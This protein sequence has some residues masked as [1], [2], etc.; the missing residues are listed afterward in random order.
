MFVAS[1]IRS[2]YVYP[3][4]SPEGHHLVGDAWPYFLRH[5]PWRRSDADHGHTHRSTSWPETSILFRKACHLSFWRVRSSPSGTACMEYLVAQVNTCP[6]TQSSTS[7]HPFCRRGQTLKIPL[8]VPQ[9]DPLRIW[10]TFPK[11]GNLCV[12]GA[13]SRPSAASFVLLVLPD[14]CCEF[15]AVDRIPKAEVSVSSF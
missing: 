11:Y 4:S 7:T 5:E 15:Y 6:A 2:T 13:C 9:D 1:C 14:V 10:G 12:I 8:M 3:F